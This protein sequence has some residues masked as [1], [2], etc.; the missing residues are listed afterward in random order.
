MSAP[1]FVHRPNWNIT[2]GHF[3]DRVSIEFQESVRNIT[4]IPEQA[5]EIA[6]DIIR[7]GEQL[8]KEREDELRNTSSRLPKSKRLV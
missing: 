8:I 6:K 1:V 7:V 5:I 3:N 4:L 2:I